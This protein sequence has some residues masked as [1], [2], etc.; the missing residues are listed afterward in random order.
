MRSLVTLLFF[1]FNIT[2]VNA[3]NPIAVS[4]MQG[5]V[6]KT[7]ST[8]VGS[9]PNTLRENFKGLIKQHVLLDSVAKQLLVKKERLDTIEKAGLTSAFEDFVAWHLAGIYANQI[10]SGKDAKVT[11]QENTTTDRD[12]VLG[13]LLDVVTVVIETAQYGKVKVEWYMIP[14]Q[15]L[16][17]AKVEGKFRMSLTLKPQYVAA[18]EQAGGNPQKFIEILRSQLNAKK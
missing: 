8:V 5:I 15:G 14:N 17:D 12:P 11:V 10:S 16:I 18:W 9:D 4:Y 13:Q 3:N 1:L 7:L 6:D 2:F